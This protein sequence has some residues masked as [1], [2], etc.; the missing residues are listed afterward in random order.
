LSPLFGDAGEQA[1]DDGE[2]VAVG[3]RGVRRKEAMEQKDGV[4]FRLVGDG[5]RQV[6]QPDQEQED[7]GDRCQQRVKGQG[8]GK[9]RDVVFISGLQGTAKEADG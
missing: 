8:A 3:Q 6:G 1:F 2:R 7:E 9:K 5:F 4:D